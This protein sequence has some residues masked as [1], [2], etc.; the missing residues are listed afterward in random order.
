MALG[1]RW[2]PRAIGEEWR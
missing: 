1:G 2:I